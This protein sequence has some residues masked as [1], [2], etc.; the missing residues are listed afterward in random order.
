MP[1]ANAASG[2]QITSLLTRFAALAWPIP[3]AEVPALV[4]T[5]GWSVSSDNGSGIVLADSA[6]P[7]NRSDAELTC[8][9]GE[10]N[11]VSFAVTD[12][13]VQQTLWRDEF[14]RDAFADIVASATQELGSASKRRHKPSPQ[15]LWELINSGRITITMLSVS[16]AVEVASARYAEAMRALGS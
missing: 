5:L 7:I 4:K 12:V 2:E 16:I 8:V 14:L 10:L 1:E 13:V 6:L 15:V 3:E 11:S 9:R